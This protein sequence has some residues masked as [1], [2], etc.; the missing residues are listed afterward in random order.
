[1]FHFLK[2]SRRCFVT[3]LAGAALFLLQACTEKAFLAEP[4]VLG[5]LWLHSPGE[6]LDLEGF[7]ID[8]DGQLLL[9]NQLS[10]AGLF[11]EL[12]EDRLLLWSRSEEPLKLQASEYRLLKNEGGAVLSMT[13]GQETVTY[14]PEPLQKP[15]SNVHYYPLYV[16]WLTAKVSARPGSVP[17][18][19]LDTDHQSLR[20]YGG[21]NN[22]FAN[23]Q[24]EGTTGFS[25]GPIASTMM[26]GAGIDYEISFMKCLTQADA[27]L[28]VRK[29]L[30]FYRESRLLCSFQAE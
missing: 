26:T 15:F 16:F 24:R 10:T 12:Q 20:G 28:P 2:I 6:G 22:F 21:V 9:V 27:L 19:Q 25:S 13:Q 7:F 29:H 3:L 23:Y 14:I 17:Y 8:S 30:F 11:W 18:L 4:D 5:R 1:M